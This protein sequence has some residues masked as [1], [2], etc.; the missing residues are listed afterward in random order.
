M[1]KH[2][3]GD[4]FKITVTSDVVISDYE[5][6]GQVKDVNDILISNLIITKIDT[7]KF[8]VKCDTINWVIGERYY[9]DIQFDLNGEIKS[10]P[11]VA[12]LVV[13]DTTT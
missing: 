11:T 2:K 10:S 6:T 3:R 4:T 9:F 13:K 12:I 7:L 8:D 1:I 5:I